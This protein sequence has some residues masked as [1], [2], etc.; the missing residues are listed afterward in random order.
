ML[1][2]PEEPEFQ[3][4]NT[5]ASNVGKRLTEQSKALAGNPGL[6]EEQMRMMEE[7]R[8]K[9]IE[10]KRRSEQAA[11]QFHQPEQQIPD[12]GIKQMKT[13]QDQITDNFPTHLTVEAAMDDSDVE[14]DMSNGEL[15]KYI[16]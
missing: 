3:M 2:A 15:E 1:D 13:D 14:C 11:E 5:C 10:R 9:A 8:R 12:K 6:S 16:D 7:N 4:I